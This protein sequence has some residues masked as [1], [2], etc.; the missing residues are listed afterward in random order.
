MKGTVG[1]AVG[2]ELN[3][4]IKGIGYTFCTV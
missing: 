1:L 3:D 2:L 4:V